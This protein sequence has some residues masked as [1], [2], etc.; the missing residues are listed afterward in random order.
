MTKRDYYDILEVARSAQ[1]SEIKSAYRKLALKY[2][3]DR[4]PG[5]AEA[6]ERF[7]EAAEAYAILA[8]PQKRG[9]YDQFGHAG[10]TGA[11]GRPDFDPTIF[12]DFGDVFGGFGDIF[13]FGDAGGRRRGGAARGADLRYDLSIPFAEAATG[14]ETTL[15]IPRIEVCERCSGTRAEPGEKPETCPQC[16]GRGQVRYQQGFLTVA[17]TCGQCRGAGKVV[18]NP[19]TACHG[20]G[21]IEQSRKLTVKIPAGI[22]TGQRLRLQ[23]EGEHGSAGGP[24]GDLYVVIQ[25]EE[26]PFYHREG[27]DLWCEV[28]VSYP[29]L[30]LGGTITVPTLDDKRESVSIP[31]GTQPES[32]FRIRGRGMP[33]V[34]GRGHGDLYVLVQ[35]EVPAKVSR[36]QKELL[37]KLDET[38]PHKS[39]EPNTRSE[40]EDRPF[41]DRVRD[42]FG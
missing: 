10:V 11:A 18:K 24:T 7:K 8:D 1:D 3:P 9:R 28:P 14:T 27:D 19:C 25:V 23:G 12:A 38:M 15:Q 20:Q 34:S 22:A 31:K 26:H 13:G 36:E 41:F 17:R 4:N 42:I 35:A 5:D 30:V 6:E 32:K 2:H 21:G 29:T 16:A 39:S 40:S 37:Q 33:H